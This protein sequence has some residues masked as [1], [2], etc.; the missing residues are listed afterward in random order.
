[1]RRPWAAVGGGALGTLLLVGI[2]NLV[3]LKE[4]I[5]PGPGDAFG[6]WTWAPS[7]AIVPNITEF[8]FFTA[9][10]ADLHA[11]VVALPITILAAALSY[12]VAREPRSFAI[13]WSPSGGRAT[14]LVV[15]ARLTVLALVL[16]SLSATNA[17]DVPVY[18]AL[19][20][21]ALLM[22][23]RSIHG[24]WRRLGLLAITAAVV[25]LVAGLL[26]LPFHQHFVALFGSLVGVREPTPFG[27]VVSHLGGL[28]VIVVLGA[29]VALLPP[30]RVALAPLLHPSVVVAVVLG[31][32]ALR[33]FLASF[34]PEA[35]PALGA[36]IVAVVA[37]VLGAA[38]WLRLAGRRSPGDAPNGWFRAGVLVGFGAVALALLA[39]RVVL[40]GFLAVGLAGAALWLGGDGVAS[41]FVGALF[42]A[43]CFV[44]AGTELVVLADDLVETDWYRM[45]TVFKF[46]NQ[47][48]VLLALGGGAL[49]ARMLRD[50]DLGPWRRAASSPGVGIVHRSAS[51]PADRPSDSRPYGPARGVGETAVV[52]RRHTPPPA[53]GWSRLGLAATAMVVAVSFFY[54]LLA[55]GPRLAQRF[56]GHPGPGTLDGLDWM[57]YGTVTHNADGR[58]LRPPIAFAD[59]RAAIDW[60]NTEVEGTPVIAEASIGAYRGNG[61]RFSIATGLPTIIG[62]ENHE[63]QQRYAEQLD[64]RVADVERL[65]DATDPEE[66][67]GI[68]RE[69]GV[70]YVVV[71]ALER[72]WTVDRRPWAS[73]EGIAAFEEMVGTSLEVAFQSGDTVVYRVLPAPA[74][75]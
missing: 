7:R 31:L 73:A 18:A 22:A 33:G 17:W 3:P 19:A 35:I 4:L 50:A 23:V 34:R 59:D 36:G 58:P 62:W 6:R 45:N 47:V 67:L 9:L 16:G 52:R 26:F 14:R 12:A 15:V 28:L 29:M 60:F 57:E 30:G 37:A 25:A 51:V 40:A 38:A 65:Y 27:Q 68:L 1:V 70:E 13:A 53:Q 66:K 49:V 74:G 54:P 11:H 21:V 75:S 2:G 41:R 69:Y 63:T 72:S 10:Y 43:A 44:G 8:P 64:G 61:S 48:W 5:A 55:T 56:D 32:A 24:A 46:Y 71:G 20:F 39:E 42:A